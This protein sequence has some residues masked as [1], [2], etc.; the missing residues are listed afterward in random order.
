MK[1]V[2][3]VMSTYNGGSN[4]ERQ[5]DS[6]LSQRKC[7]IR[8]FIRDD[9][10]TDNTCDIIN[11]YIQ[12]H[13][14]SNIILT[15]GCNEGFQKSFWDALS[16]CGHADYY[17]FSDQDDVWYEEKL[18]KCIDKMESD[19]KYS[20]AKMA[21][22]RFRRTDP[23]LRPYNEQ[24]ILLSPERITPKIALTK[25][26][27]YGASIVINDKARHLICKC[28]P[29]N[30]T[31]TG[32]GHD[33]WAGTLCVWFGKIYYVDEALYNWI[34]YDNSVTGDGTKW[35]GY[36]YILSQIFL[37]KTTYMNPAPYLLHYYNDLLK[38]D[39]KEFLNMVVNYK[40]HLLYRI[41]LICDKD[42]KRD[43]LKGTLLL[44]FSILRGIY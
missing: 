32:A 22:C 3:V 41:K 27:A 36:R 37:K 7:N 4:I 35:N 31:K 14:L 44:K 42:F 26:F 15:R 29:K 17:A 43:T 8:I 24:T 16:E 20:G 39:E 33:A 28:F 21:Y 23:D 9:G 2:I 12:R 5:L 13:N 19:I 1:D 34:R 10:S 11:S 30:M 18:I 40:H 6:I 25:I 38:T